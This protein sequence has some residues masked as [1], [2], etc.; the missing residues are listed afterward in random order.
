MSD[1]T[2]DQLKKAYNAALEQIA[3]E[4]IL[5]PTFDDDQIILQCTGW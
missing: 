3:A 4:S 1:L 5:D 2:L